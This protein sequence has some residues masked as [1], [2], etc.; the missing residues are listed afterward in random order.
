MD[1]PV[2]GLNAGRLL[3]AM[4]EAARTAGAF[5]LSQFRLRLPGWGENKAGNEF[6]SFVDTESEKAIRLILEKAQPGAAFYGEETEQSLGEGLT[7]VVDPLDGTTNFISGFDYWAVSIALWEGGAGPVMGLVYRPMTDEIFTALRGGGAY[8][9]GIRLNQAQP[10]ALKSALIATGTPYRSPDTMDSFFATV[11]R[12]ME[13]FHDLRRSGSAAIDLSYTAA[14]YLQG[15]WEVDL[16][17]YDV[18][19]G[20]LMLSETGHRCS[21]FSGVPY[22]PFRHRSFVCARPGLMEALEEAVRLGYG[23][24]E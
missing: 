2:P 18:A 19:A 1:A 24:L 8:R 12:V 10:L 17:P 11:R 4:E 7:W 9:N 6:V 3:A 14:G 20:L 5:Q 13:V 16:Q 15:F 21:A 22:D 23:N